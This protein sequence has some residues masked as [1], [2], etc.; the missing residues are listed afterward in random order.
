MSKP[1]VQ[2]NGD[3]LPVFKFQKFDHAAAMLDRGQVRLGSIND[4]RQSKYGGQIDDA[5]EGRIHLFDS[6]TQAEGGRAIEAEGA[7]IF[8]VTSKFLSGTLS[9]AIEEKK[10]TAVLIT[11]PVEFARRI[12]LE[13]PDLDFVGFDVC[14]YS[15]RR[16]ANFGQSDSELYRNAACAKPAQYKDQMESRFVWRSR[17][18]ITDDA[19]LGN[20]DIASLTIPVRY[21]NLKGFR[22]RDQRRIKTVVNL[23][24][25]KISDFEIDYPNE[26]SSPVIFENELGRMLGF[27]IQGRS[28]SGGRLTG[29]QF[30]IIMRGRDILSCNNLLNDIESIEYLF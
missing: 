18:A 19:I 3:I 17:Q 11:D 4:F 22:P 2:P 23:K 13:N 27:V 20:Y 29:G 30:G 1:G 7:Y 25:G 10:E 15:G 21:H 5:D 12:T 8:C 14:D 9:W 26:I 24:D 28:V 16:R 6:L